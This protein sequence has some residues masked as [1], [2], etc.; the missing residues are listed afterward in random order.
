MTT[1][2]VAVTEGSGKN[3]ATYSFSEDATT[4]QLQ[5]VALNE[6]DGTDIALSAKVGALTETAPASD[7]A[8]SG[9][10]GRL[11]RVAQ[12]ITSLIALL[13]ATLTGSGNLKVAVQEALP[14]G[15]AIIGQVLGASATISTGVTRA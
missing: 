4:K 7:T 3:V 5:R 6:Q 10:N 12:R 2:N 8:S 1:A 11:Q 13:P 15:T 14:A 9:I